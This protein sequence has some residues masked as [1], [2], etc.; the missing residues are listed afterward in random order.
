MCIRDRYSSKEEMRAKMREVYGGTSS[1]KNQVHATWQFVNDMKPGDIVFVKKGMH[2]I[3]GRGIV[4]SD[5]IFDASRRD[6][7]KNIRQIN[8]TNKGEWEHPG[9]AVMKTLTDIT[10]YTD[11]VEKLNA[12]LD[13]YKRQGIHGTVDG[14][15]L[16]ISGRICILTGI[17]GLLQYCFLGG[18]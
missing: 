5:Y 10:S 11:Y 12:L 7:Y 6:E 13:V 1:Y 15:A 17:I 8:W 18:C 2:R 9:Q 14:N 4:T 3:V 16:I